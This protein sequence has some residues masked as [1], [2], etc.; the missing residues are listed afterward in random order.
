MTQIMAFLTAHQTVAALVAYY[1]ISAG[2]GALPA[3]VATSGDFYK[4]FFSFSNTLAGN[5]SRAFS[6]KLGQTAA[7]D[8]N[9]KP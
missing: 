5:L 2:I 4:W 3:P 7:P 9:A 1:V 8:P 6:S